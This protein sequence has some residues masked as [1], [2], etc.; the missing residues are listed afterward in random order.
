VEAKALGVPYVEGLVEAM[1]DPNLDAVLLLDQ[2]WFHGWPIEIAC[3][4]NKPVFCVPYLAGDLGHVEVVCQKVE[5]AQ[6]PLY[7]DRP[8]RA[9]PVTRRLHKLVSSRVGPVRLAFWHSTAEAYSLADAIDWCL[10]LFP[11]PAVQAR[12]AT[13]G[14]PDDP[15]VETVLIDFGEGRGAQ[16]S[17]VLQQGRLTRA[18]VVAEHGTV[19]L[20]IPYRLAWSHRGRV[21][22]EKCLMRATLEQQSLRHF[23]DA[24][25]SDHPEPPRLDDERRTSHVLQM[26][27]EIATGPETMSEPEA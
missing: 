4:L 7:F 21:Y 1:N 3:R 20:Q 27:R 8:A 23:Y 19:D 6:L 5:S 25:H 24:L 11:M 17:R 12:L 15:V 26:I 10:Q 22:R 16:I 2:Q 18:H 14:D 9:N 13:I